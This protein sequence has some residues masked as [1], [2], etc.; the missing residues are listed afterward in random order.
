MCETISCLKDFRR[1]RGKVNVRK[2]KAP[3]FQKALYFELAKPW[4]LSSRKDKT[5]TELCKGYIE[6]K[7]VEPENPLQRFVAQDLYKYFTK[8]KLVIFFHQN[9][10]SADNEFK[11][12][13]MFKKENM[14]YER[15]GKKTLEMAVKGTPYEAVLD[16]YVSHNM[17]LFSSEPDI[18]KVLKISKKFPHIVML[19]MF[20]V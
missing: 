12:Y 15:F 19:G 7:E 17:I 1:F 14:H 11:A 5:V 13:A 10:G 4:F 3:H 2:P 20:I 8:S 16:F 18:K 6:E 9:P